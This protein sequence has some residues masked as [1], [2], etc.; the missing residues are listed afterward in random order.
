MGGNFDWAGTGQALGSAGQNVVEARRYQQEKADIEKRQKEAEKRAQL[1]VLEQAARAKVE[2]AQRALQNNP[3]DPDLRAAA[4][5]AAREHESVLSQITGQPTTIYPRVKRTIQAPEKLRPGAAA[6]A[7]PTPPV[8]AGAPGEPTEGIQPGTATP[9]GTT[10]GLKGAPG[11]QPEAGGFAQAPQPVTREEI[12]HGLGASPEAQ[13]WTGAIGARLEQQKANIR[14]LANDP[15]TRPEQIQSLIARHNQDVSRARA[16]AAR[17]GINPEQAEFLF[18][19]YTD[20]EG[21]ITVNEVKGRQEAAVA[22]AYKAQ[23][24]AVA[25]AVTRYSNNRSALGRQAMEQAMTQYNAMYEQMTRQG[26]DPASVGAAEPYNIEAELAGWDKGREVSPK[27]QADDARARA[28]LHAWKLWEN[29]NRSPETLAILGLRPAENKGKM[30]FEH[31]GMVVTDLWQ[32]KVL[33]QTD[34]SFRKRFEGAGAVLGSAGTGDKDDKAFLR[35]VQRRSVVLRLDLRAS[36]KTVTGLEAVWNTLNE[37]EKKYAMQGNGPE[38]HI[39]LWQSLQ[40]AR[41]RTEEIKAKIEELTTLRGEIESPPPGGAAAPAAPAAPRIYRGP[42]VLVEGGQTVDLEGIWNA[43]Q[44]GGV[45]SKEQWNGLPKKVQDWLRQN[46]VQP[47]VSGLQSSSVSPDGQRAIKNEEG[48]RLVAYRDGNRYSIG[49][50][51]PSRK[52][53]RITQAE[54]ERRFQASLST[55]ADPVAQIARDIP[56]RQNQVDALASLAYNYGRNVFT[57]YS[58]GRNLVAALRK[59]N[60]EAAARIIERRSDNPARRRREAAMLRAT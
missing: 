28:Q 32:A 33:W 16:M 21:Q 29:G 60:V 38:G 5:A 3:S 17:F 2:A 6:P 44:A 4:D 34:P 35:E 22:T 47:G 54:A 19:S 27:T 1:T 43:V 25:A 37:R 42:K 45:I 18:P 12:E 59:G 58:W 8:P 7:A 48:L 51:T 41:I 46:G 52:G 13:R 49:Y 36:E 53:E 24:A 31:R 57:T 10:A 20:E 14:A 55:H 11:T 30:G 40:T 15:R 50:G 26:L 56:L 39:K 23:L 9:A